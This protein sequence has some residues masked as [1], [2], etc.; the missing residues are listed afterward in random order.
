MLTTKPQE[1]ATLMA[2][3]CADPPN[4]EPRLAYA[5]WAERNA[6]D[7]GVARAEYIR[8]TVRLYRDNQLE[9]ETSIRLRTPQ[10][11]QAWANGVQSL[12]VP[13]FHYVRGFVASVRATT[14]VLLQHGTEIAVRCPLQYVSVAGGANGHVAA[15]LKAPWMKHVISLDLGN[16]ELTDND[17]HLLAESGLS[18]LRWVNLDQNSITMQAAEEM[19]AATAAGRFPELHTLH[20]PLPIYDDDEGGFTV[21]RPEAGITLRQKYGELAWLNPRPPGLRGDLY[22]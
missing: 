10:R 16:N 20:L 3:V 17:V 5:D 11:K 9:S 22:A 12:G 14:S 7:E 4:D 18:E 21:W 2:A 8:E 19:A 1:E 6:G 15:L 13:I